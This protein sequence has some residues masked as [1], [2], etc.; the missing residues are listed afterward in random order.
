MCA[1][2]PRLLRPRASLHPEAAN[3]AARV[4]VNGGTVSGSTLNEVSRFCRAID[5]AGIRDRFGRLNLFCGTGLDAC[6]VPLYRSY[7]PLGTVIGLSVDQSLGSPSFAEA[8]YVETGTSGGL[9]NGTS[10]HLNTGFDVTD[11]ADERHL[12]AFVCDPDLINNKSFVGSDNFPDPDF[13]L[14]GIRTGGSGTLALGHFAFGDVLEAAND[15]NTTGMH[16]LGVAQASGGPHVLYRN[17]V[18]VGSGSSTAR[19]L[20]SGIPYYV[21]ANNRKN[22]AGDNLQ[23]RLGA[24]SIGDGMTQTQATAFYDAMLEFQNALGRKTT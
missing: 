15:L 1:M 3:W 18:S 5:A 22:V 2:S 11:H 9:N 20:V 21:F 13:Y 6:L 10:K 14:N 7:T 17:A 16:V 12:S 23:A 8:D 19:T 24:Y 4:Q